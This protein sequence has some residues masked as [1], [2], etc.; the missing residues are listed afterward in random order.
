S[1]FPGIL[2]Q[3]DFVA[4]RT[5][6]GQ[7]ALPPQGGQWRHEDIVVTAEPGRPISIAAPRTPLQ[8]ILLR[9]RAAFPANTLFLGDHWERGYGDLE[10][11]ALVPNRIMPWYFLASSGEQTRGY[12]VETGAGAICFWQT[13]GEGISLWLDVRNGGA[14]V[15]LGERVLDAALIRQTSL[16]PG[17]SAYATARV[18]CKALCEKPRLPR[19]PVYGGNNWYYTYGKNFTAADIVRDSKII[20]D[21][22]P[23][24]SNR[25]FMLIDEGWAKAD[26]G[27][28]PTSATRAGFPDM[29]KLAS[30]MKQAGARPAIWI[31][32]LLTVEKLPEGWR[33]AG[34][35]KRISDPYFVIDP[36]L[37]GALHHIQE[38]VRVVR[39]WG[40]ELIKHDYSTYEVLGRW[41][42]QMGATL[43]DWGW[44]FQDRTRTTAEILLAF[45]KALREAA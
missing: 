21:L 18:L 11:R 3:P 27:A 44:H 15:E 36:S 26:R 12:G 10:W 39:K 33:L 23:S 38:S 37:P 7:V 1:A 17:R 29:P 6:Q 31:R 20:S 32:P 5:A 24:A 34:S 16:E 42:F 28:G 25:P 8:H 35:A 2:R 4:V 9:W 22:A 40:F 19:A 45:Y 41:G 30:D 43:T 13:D 14:A